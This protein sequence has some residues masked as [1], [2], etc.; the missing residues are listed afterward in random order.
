MMKCILIFGILLFFAPVFLFGCNTNDTLTFD[1]GKTS[2]G[3]SSYELKLVYEADFSKSLDVVRENDLFTT[4]KRI[5]KPREFDWVLEGPGSAWTE[6]AVLHV[7]NAPHQNEPGHPGHVVLWNTQIFPANFLLEFGFSPKDSNKGLAIIFFSATAKSGG[8]I[9]GL[10]Q[11]R[12]AGIFRNYHSGDINCYHTSFWAM[13]RKTANLRKNYGFHL[14]A[15]GKDYIAGQ[16]PGPHKVRLLKVNGKIELETSGKLALSWQ[17]DGK[18]LSEGHIGLRTM[19]HTGKVRYTS[20][21]VWKVT[22]KD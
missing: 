4:T 19:A 9:F 3:S 17:D 20:F 8:D 16:G 1:I 13:P 21:K 11:A 2:L 12:R 5:K 10:K 18:V 7:T 6:R 22:Q 15:S 14:V